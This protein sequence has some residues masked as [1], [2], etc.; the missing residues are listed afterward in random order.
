MSAAQFVELA[1]AKKNRRVR[2]RISAARRI[3]AS[4]IRSGRYQGLHKRLRR[5]P[6]ILDRRLCSAILITM[7]AVGP[8]GGSGA[9]VYPIGIPTAPIAPDI[10]LPSLPAPWTASTT[11][12]YYVKQGGSAVN[13]GTP[14]APRG[15]LPDLSAAPDG[16]VVVID[17][18][19]TFTGTDITL[20]PVGASGTANYIWVVGS[21]QYGLGSG[22]TKA[23]V[24][25]TG[26]VTFTGSFATFDGIDFYNNTSNQ[27]GITWDTVKTMLFRS[28]NFRANGAQRSANSGTSLQGTSTS[29]RASNIVFY[30][31]EWRDWGKW[32][33]TSLASDIDCH[34]MQ[35]NRFVEDIWFLDSR[36]FHNQGDGMQFTGD[37]NTQIPS[38]ARRVYIGRNTA[39][40]N[41]QCG[42]WLKFGD[43]IVR[44]QNTVYNI[45]HQS[46]A[47]E[48]TAD[49]IAIGGQYEF[50]NVWDIFNRIYDCDAGINYHSAYNTE[51]TGQNLY[52]IGNVISNCNA[53]TDVQTGSPNSNGCPI[54]F[55]QGRN[56][57]CCFNSIWQY[58]GHGIA[59]TPNDN[60]NA[61]IENNIVYGRSNSACF[62]ILLE[63]YIIEPKV[64]NNIFPTSPR[65]SMSG[66]SYTTVA[67]FQSA[68]S[69]NRSNNQ[70]ANPLFVSTVTGASGNFDTQSG[71]PARDTGLLTT[72]VF[73]TF[74]GAVGVEIRKDF[75]GA[76]RPANSIY[77]VGAYEH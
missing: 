56:V 41:L 57:Y 10:A 64:R 22:T 74:F 32:N 31:C 40:E 4:G 28:C 19:A 39:Y 6:S 38:D 16:S 55:W 50:T 35:I 34:G 54:A 42:F 45:S 73:A 77:D 47:G 26:D 61:V 75:S 69:S 76:A 20:N 63:S 13:N 30:D 46:G 33:P 66:A 48:G 60:T 7:T 71:S 25:F 9:Y 37:P 27:Q 49:S 17:N 5:R 70:A 8:G 12:F 2:R 18:T 67:S 59:F 65:F 11:G 43:T 29:N 68:S 44:S 51:V 72:D 3:I 53:S 62:D 36:F 1:P 15:T 52:V 21:Q 24:Q 23:L 14:G 58:T